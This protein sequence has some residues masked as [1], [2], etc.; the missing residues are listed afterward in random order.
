MLS[1][2][3][4]YTTA[5]VHY[6]FDLIRCHFWEI[7]DVDPWD[8]TQHSL[9]ELIHIRITY[10]RSIRIGSKTVSAKNRSADGWPALRNEAPKNID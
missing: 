2:S 10:I 1:M 4:R 9:V 6:G 8:I 5:T 3:V 7:V